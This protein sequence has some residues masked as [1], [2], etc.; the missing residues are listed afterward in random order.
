MCGWRGE[1]GGMKMGES[2]FHDNNIFVV[3]IVIMMSLMFF[4]GGR[5]TIIFDNIS[6]ASILKMHSQ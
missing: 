4:R 2:V 3:A 5:I 6:Q 1:T